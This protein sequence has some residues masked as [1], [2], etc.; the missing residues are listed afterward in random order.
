MSE[1]DQVIDAIR[2]YGFS[3]ASEDDLQVAL[4]E[5]LDRAELRPRREVRVAGGRI[6][7]IVGRVGIEV[8]TKG[9]AA[10]VRRQIESYAKEPTLDSFILVTG[11]SQHSALPDELGGKPVHVEVLMG[12]M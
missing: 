7:I 1:L 9:S 2:A 10:D 11:R 5:A 3:Y 6:D 12:A 8:K 4:A